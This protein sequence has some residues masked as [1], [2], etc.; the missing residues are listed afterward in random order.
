LHALVDAGGAARG[1]KFRERV[2]RNRE[3]GAGFIAS[4][5]EQIETFPWETLEFIDA[6][7]VGF[8]LTSA[9]AL[10]VTADKN[11]SI[12]QENYDERR[13]NYKVHTY[14]FVSL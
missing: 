9:R 14:S 3:R 11:N 8:V 12:V 5:T 2:R 7:G 13:N 6:R 4:S 1:G 10:H